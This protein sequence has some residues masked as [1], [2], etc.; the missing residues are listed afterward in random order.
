[1][2]YKSIYRKVCGSFTYERGAAIKKSYFQLG[3]EKT[4]SNY[5]FKNSFGLI[6][7]SGEFLNPF[8]LS[9]VII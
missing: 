5:N 6:I 9:R 1:M 2:G 3:L 8:S 7:L 4:Q